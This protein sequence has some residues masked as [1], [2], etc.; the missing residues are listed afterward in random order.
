MSPRLTFAALLLL[1][2][3]MPAGAA[4][5]AAGAP[6][7]ARAIVDKSLKTMVFE[8][9]SISASV[10]LKDV[11]QGGNTRVRTIAVKSKKDSQ[12]L[13]KTILHFTQPT[14]LKGTGFLVLE[15]QGV[16]DEQFLYLSATKKTKRIRSDQQDSAF[17]GTQ[18]SYAD[19]QNR[20]VE[21]N[22]YALK[23]E[24]KLDRFDC[25][26]IESTPK[27]PS[28]EQYSRTLSWIAKSTFV[29]LRMQ[30]FD[31]SG[32]MVKVFTVK[33]VKVVDGLYVVTDSIMKNVKKNRH[34]EM[35]VEDLKTGESLSDDLFTVSRLEKM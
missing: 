15:R 11:D 9:P 19:L 8:Q 22:T 27:R 7:D 30:M 16:Q 35:V 20:D 24:E 5:H 29:P 10:T 2:T 31:K 34:T 14:D 23:G 6:A 3:L 32:V 12:G 18:Y 33:D 21:D 1:T 26:V 13:S 17:M 25:Y 4:L 28:E